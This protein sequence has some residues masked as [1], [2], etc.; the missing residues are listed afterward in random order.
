M[1][2]V[3]VECHAWD[4]GSQSGHGD[5]SAGRPY[6]EIPQLTSPFEYLNREKQQGRKREKVVHCR[7]KRGVSR[8]FVQSKM[9]MSSAQTRAR[10]EQTSMLV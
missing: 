10:L 4:R 3:V 1:T 5:R 8:S 6:L 9:P 7:R 2:L